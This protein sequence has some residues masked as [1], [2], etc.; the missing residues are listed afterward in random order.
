M[1]FGR[2][3]FKLS[4][5]KRQQSFSSGTAS[6][7]V[8]IALL[9]RNR[10]VLLAFW[11]LHLRSLALT[12]VYTQGGQR[13]TLYQPPSFLVLISES[14]NDHHAD[15]QGPRFYEPICKFAEGHDKLRKGR[16]LSTIIAGNLG[17]ACQLIGTRAPFNESKSFLRW[18]L[19]ERQDSVWRV[20]FF[21]QPNGLTHRSL[22]DDKDQKPTVGA[23]ETFSQVFC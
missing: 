20:G 15:R 13:D 10:L 19:Q 21:I 4:S 12:L 9:W 6:C 2:Q 14:P 3:R 11:T 18:S 16:A 22:Q 8:H 5:L 7:Q 1:I 23:K 17:W